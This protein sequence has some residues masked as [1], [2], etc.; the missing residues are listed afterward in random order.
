MLT[1][2]REVIIV[3]GC[4]RLGASLAGTL[5]RQGYDVMVIDKDGDS[6]RKL[7]PNF[8]GFEIQ[9][10]ATDPAI[11]LS[12]GIDN[13]RLVAA[14]TDNDNVNCMV[15]QIASRLYGVSEVFARLNDTDKEH[16]LDGTNVHPIYPSRLS[17]TE[18]QRLSSIEF[19]LLY[20]EGRQ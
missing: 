8:S 12:A 3:A 7:P 6:F 9:G 18:I 20:E 10:D 15:A 11:L 14:V 13:V 1:M 17:L 16:L 5:S 19:G 4:G 2:K